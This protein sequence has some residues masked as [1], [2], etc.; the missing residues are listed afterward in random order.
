M[1]T[2]FIPIRDGEVSKSILR[3]DIFSLLVKDFFIVFF[4]T[5]E[6]AEY[7]KNEFRDY[8]NIAVELIPPATH[9]FLEEVFAF[10]FLYSLHTESIRVKIQYAYRARSSYILS[11]PKRIL[12]FFGQWY[13]VRAMW[14]YIYALLRDTSFDAFFETYKPAGVFAANLISN[15]DARLIKAAR[16]YGTVSV[17]MPKGWDNLTLK[18][19]LS[20]FPDHLL[21]QTML[22]Q[23]D[24]VSLLDYPSDKI[25]ITGFPKFD[26]Y[27]NHSLL[28]DRVS[29]L[30]RLG[31]DP[32]KKTILYAGAGDQ[33]APYDEDILRDLVAY[34]SKQHTDWQI[35]VRPHPKYK[36][37][38]EI[39]PESS[40][41]VLDM[42]GVAV[43]GRAGNF[44]FRDSDVVHLMNSL[45]HADVLV[46]TAST[47]G[48]E[49]AIFDKP[50]ITIGYDG[51]KVLHPHV[52]VS[53]Y[54]RYVHLQRVLQTG[55][56]PV[57]RSFGE[58][59][60]LLEEEIA[61]P[62]KRRDA[63]HRMALENAGIVDGG[64][65]KRIA[66]FLKGH[67]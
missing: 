43:G 62:E 9:P 57:A 19:F 42:P 53:R 10:I 25:F 24:A 64:A 55:A 7:F 29:F 63:R 37:R 15:E 8:K 20:I 38:S 23:Q 22:M 48:I 18:T 27:A 2:I 49:A 65:G 45:A 26:M 16:R 66:E 36:Y 41:W 14:R 47:L 12:W 11:I 33:L 28:E 21:V 50:S 3:S 5:K 44:E 30:R 61:S 52:S 31:L 34:I 40:A 6:K 4:V 58:L 56:M 51:D 1:K 35:L 17:G 67:I 32:A 59:T 54:Y 60:A 39:I 13:F 46:H